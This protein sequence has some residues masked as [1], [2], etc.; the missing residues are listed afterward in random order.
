MNLGETLFACMKQDHKVNREKDVCPKF[1]KCADLICQAQFS[2]EHD[3]AAVIYH[4]T[5]NTM[6][7]ADPTMDSSS[8][9]QIKKRRVFTC[10]LLHHP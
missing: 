10:S 4:D 8:M 2:A 6:E 1:C 9:E 3:G 7:Q 5:M